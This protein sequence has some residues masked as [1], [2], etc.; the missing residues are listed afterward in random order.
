MTD[1]EQT[2]SENIVL[3]GNHSLQTISLALLEQWR[4][5]LRSEIDSLE[6]TQP[7]WWNTDLQETY[8]QAIGEGKKALRVVEREIARRSHKHLSGMLQGVE[9]L[10][11]NSKGGD[12]D[13]KQT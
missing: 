4:D 5:D 2:A 7:S 9:R 1:K 8:S 12:G 13:K 10:L 6:S 3:L 11:A